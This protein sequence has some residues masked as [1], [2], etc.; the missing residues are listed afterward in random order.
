MVIKAID[1]STKQS[2]K[3]SVNVKVHIGDIKKKRKRQPRKKGSGGGGQKS[4][5][6]QSYTPVYIQSGTPQEPNSNVNS[7]ALLEKLNTM[8]THH[9][10][11]KNS[12]LSKVP[13]PV[14]VPVPSVPV[15]PV[16][17]PSVHPSVHPVHTPSVHPS[18]HTPSSNSS[19]ASSLS[20]SEK[21][22][23]S[24]YENPLYQKIYP[25]K[26]N[27]NALLT[28]IPKRETDTELTRKPVMRK[29][30]SADEGVC[31]RGNDKTVK[32]KPA[33]NESEFRIGGI[34]PEDVDMI[35]EGRQTPNPK[36]KAHEN[37]A[38][39]VLNYTGRWV[40]ADGARGKNIKLLEK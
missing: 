8:A 15:H 39:F 21:S 36:K 7:N 30:S 1:K 25:R 32:P 31:S 22:F 23:N 24:Y 2:V 5:Y 12:L 13:V 6:Q 27:E 19:I 40:K 33:D 35:I 10:E 29:D 9:E 28:Q 18:V 3:Q 11:L 34:I 38:G 14:P 20:D 4:S 16:H 37:E 26:E 17:T